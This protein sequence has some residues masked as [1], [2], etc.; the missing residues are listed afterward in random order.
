MAY[1]S[2]SAG[3]RGGPV[4][5]CGCTTPPCVVPPTGYVFNLRTI[6][7]DD[8]GPR[9]WYLLDQQHGQ[10]IARQL[11]Y[12]ALCCVQQIYRQAL[13]T[14][15]SLALCRV[16]LCKNAGKHGTESGTV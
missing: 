5:R 4:Y 1:H 15:W 14:A 9:C 16:C 11:L 6:S 7:V 2:R 3:I 12:R 8:L 13:E 10:G